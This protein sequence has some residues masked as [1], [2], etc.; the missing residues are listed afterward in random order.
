[1]NIYKHLR[2]D[3]IAIYVCTWKSYLDEFDIIETCDVTNISAAK[4]FRVKCAMYII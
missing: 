1:M 2:I 3:K 4:F